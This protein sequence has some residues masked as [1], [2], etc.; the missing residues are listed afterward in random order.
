MN[1]NSLKENLS[2]AID[3]GYMSEIDSL[4]DSLLS[5]MKPSMAADELSELIFKKYTTFKSNLLSVVLEMALRKD[6][7]LAQVH[8]PQNP[9]FKLCF[10]TGSTELFDCFLEEAAEKIVSDK[11]AEEASTYYFDLYTVAVQLNDLFFD[12]FTRCVKGMDYNGAF[13]TLDE[14][15]NVVLINREDYETLEDVS[16]QY[17]KIVG[18]RDIIKRLEEISESYDDIDG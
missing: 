4:L 2:I 9:I 10:L 15:D 12:K 17:N 16:E 13:S 18:R 1:I 7:N 5:A 3:E 6:I 11:S 8:Y 14:N